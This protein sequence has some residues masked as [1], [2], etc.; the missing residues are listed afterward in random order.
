LGRTA[1]FFD[2]IQELENVNADVRF[3][4][5]SIEPNLLIDD[6]I[7]F[8]SGSDKFVPHFHIPLQSGS[9]AILR[10]MR[11]RYLRELYTER[12]SLIKS[13]M[14]LCCIGADVITGFPG[15][16]E[17]NFLETYSYLNE[18][19]VSYLHVFTY[20]ERSNTL[21][22]ESKDII[23]TDV[24]KKRT[25]MLRILSDKKLHEFYTQNLGQES[26]VLFEGSADKEWLYGFTGN[27]VRVR[28]PFDEMLEYTICKVR[29][30]TINSEGAVDGKI[31][32]P[33]LGSPTLDF[34]LSTF[35]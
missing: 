9:N 2:L 19:N 32:N 34:Q 20:S 10:K 5:S 29:L 3:R 22:A 11:R 15:E 8:V 13:L 23:P 26:E 12:V 25:K 35:N 30:N 14:P 27:Y 17:E 6:I 18:L 7:R 33:I 1:T 28:I 4:I 31:V 16:T 24:R 21:A